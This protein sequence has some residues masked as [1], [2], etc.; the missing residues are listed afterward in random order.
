MRLSKVFRKYNRILLMIFMSLLLVVFL[1]GDVIGRAARSSSQ[2]SRKVGQAFG[3]TIDT[4]A[5]QRSQSDMNVARQLGFP[6]LLPAED[7]VAELLLIEEA[8]QAGIRVSRERAQQEI[9]RRGVDE[10]HMDVVRKQSGR[11]LVSIYD[12]VG[13]WLAAAQLFQVQYE[14]LGDSLPRLEQEYQKT[15]QEA[16]VKLSV[17]DAQAF[18]SLVEEPTEAELQDH[19][20][21]GKDRDTEHADDELRFGYLLHERVRIEYLTVDPNAI[22]DQ[23]S[24]REAERKRYYQQNKQK[25][26]TYVPRATTQPAQP[27]QSAFK[28]VLQTYEQ[29]SERVREDCRTAK[30]IQ[31]AAR[32]VSDIRREANQPWASG[33]LG[34][35][36]YRAVPPSDRIVSFEALRD[37]YSSRFPVEHHKTELLNKAG[38]AALSGIGR[39]VY[40]SG[41]QRQP[42]SEMALRIKGL[43]TPPE[44]D[45]LPVLNPDEPSALMM[46]LQY[47]PI[48]RRQEAY[49]AYLFR[50][51][52]IAPS[53]PPASLDEVREQVVKDVRLV[54]ALR[55]AERHAQWLAEQAREVGL[56]D[57]VEEAAE[58][59]ELLR[60]AEAP[61]SAPS[62]APALPVQPASRF[63]RA[64]GPNAPRGKF[65]RSPSWMQDVGL[66]QKLH[67]AVFALP[68][69][70]PQGG[71]AHR[72]ATVQL[73]KDQK[74][75]VV[76]LEEVKPIYAG[77]FEKQRDAL[78][79]SS[80]MRQ[81]QSL[82]WQSWYD[83][84]NIKRRTGFVPIDPEE[85]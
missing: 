41:R 31:S 76:Q 66:S 23:I 2:S 73:A 59:K 28:Q 45:T 82:L 52:G 50:V 32:A 11:S 48:T 42:A 33:K 15:T 18:T 27:G 47:N 61:A 6:P 29:A 75:I 70:A 8:R 43:F 83:P 40:D 51:V 85:P 77:A 72:I 79:R 22:R 1:V 17:I 38:L 13:S 5:L 54:K 19:F 44:D 64:L 53:G 34:D 10:G 16:V 37:K 12:A 26:I 3:L 56:E 58:L 14:A 57:A 71:A 81:V 36:G 80:A 24:V 46:S 55:M 67:D 65:T 63:T 25:Y 35:D 62:S 78:R 74:W 60:I 30:A 68:E 20:E 21:A 84:E 49:Q 9:S 69:A 39:A 4:S 7:A